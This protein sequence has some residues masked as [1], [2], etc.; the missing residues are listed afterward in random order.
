M[1]LSTKHM[2]VN[3][4]IK[5]LFVPRYLHS[6]PDVRLKFVEHSKDIKL[7]LQISEKD[8]DEGVRK[9]AAERAHELQGEQHR[10]AA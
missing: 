6:N 2:G 9:A 7:L 10:K 3:M 4:N 8:A 1:T 5:D